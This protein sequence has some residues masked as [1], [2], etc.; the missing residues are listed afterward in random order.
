MAREGLGVLWSGQAAWPAEFQ[1]VGLER[2]VQVLVLGADD[3]R[4][5]KGR[6][7]NE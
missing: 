2:L 6:E 4:E 3:L 7:F 5:V 1:A